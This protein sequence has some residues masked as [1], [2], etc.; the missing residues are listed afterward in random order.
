MVAA[1]PGQ[2]NTNEAGRPA[3]QAADQSGTEKTDESTITEE[4]LPPE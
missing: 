4:D 1:I 3:I 2:P